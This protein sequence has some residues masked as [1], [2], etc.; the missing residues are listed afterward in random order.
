MRFFA[1][2]ARL[3]EKTQGSAK[4]ALYKAIRPFKR[5]QGK[6]SNTLLSTIKKQLKELDIQ[7][8]HQAIIKAQDRIIWEIWSTGQVFRRRSDSSDDDMHMKISTDEKP[9][10]CIECGK[11]FKK[12]FGLKRHIRVHFGNW[13]HEQGEYNP[14][15]CRLVIIGWP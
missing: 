10:S 9:F 1:H 11:W 3:E 14:N 7:D 4:V 13:P 15:T 8:F 12:S 5:P 2:I 6:P